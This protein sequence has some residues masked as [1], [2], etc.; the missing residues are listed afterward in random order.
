VAYEA[1][2]YNA[3]TGRW[4]AVDPDFYK[5]PWSSPYAFA[6]NS[7]ISFID[8][9]GKGPGKIINESSSSIKITGDGEI[10]DGTKTKTV[11]GSIILNPGDIFEVET[12]K[13]GEKV[14]NGGKITRSNGTVENVLIQDIDF[15]DAE[16]DQ[17]FVFDDGIIFDDDVDVKEGDPEFNRNPD[18]FVPKDESLDSD[19]S[20]ADFVLN[21][22]KGE[23]KINEPLELNTGEVKLSD[24]KKDGKSTGKIRVDESSINIFLQTKEK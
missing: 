11:R 19:E 2:I 4:L 7:P 3:S 16:G 23:L 12:R 6:I 9:Q 18:K 14:V 5:Y 13:E 20:S 1:R 8:K 24:D 17:T 10:I 15:I 21:P 22:N